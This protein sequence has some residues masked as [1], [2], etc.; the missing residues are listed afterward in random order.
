MK[1]RSNSEW[2]IQLSSPPAG[3]L[4]F[5]GTSNVGAVVVVGATRFPAGSQAGPAEDL[6]VHRG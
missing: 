3:A 6:G 4:P 2:A 1:I 5:A